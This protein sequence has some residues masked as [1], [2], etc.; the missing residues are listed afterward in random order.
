[1]GEA[2]ELELVE[3]A[4]VGQDD[5]VGVALPVLEGGEQVGV[6]LEHPVELVL[7][8][9]RELPHQ[10]QLDDGA[11]L[12]GEVVEEGREGL[13][14]GRARELDP[15][16]HEVPAAH[17]PGLDGAGGGVDVDQQHVAGVDLD[18][19][20]G[21]GGTG[22]PGVPGR[23][24]LGGGVPVA[25]G[26]VVQLPG[27][28][29]RLEV[30]QA[31][32]R[33]VGGIGGERVDRAVADGDADRARLGVGGV[34]PGLGD[35]VGEGPL[36]D[37]GGGQQLDPRGHLDHAGLVRAPPRWGGSAR[38]RWASGRPRRRRAGRGCRGA[39]RR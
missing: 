28:E 5:Q 16:Q 10:G 7:E 19:V 12:V 37:P 25:E 31:D 24:D 9:Q 20:G 14:V 23:A 8:R 27:R 1:M 2:R 38:G 36:V 18:V 17:P 32:E 11:G 3:V 6:V 21:L 30:G 13:D 33:G 29:G 22:V 26:D 4:L 35:E 34:G 15:P 39:G